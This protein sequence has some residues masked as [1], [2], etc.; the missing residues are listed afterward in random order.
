[1]FGV[2]VVAAAEATTAIIITPKASAAE[3]H[4]AGAADALAVAGAAKAL[5]VARAVKALATAKTLAAGAANK[6]LAAAAA[7]AAPQTAAAFPAAEAGVQVGV[8]VGGGYKLV[9]N[10]TWCLAD[11][12][13]ARRCRCRWGWVVGSLMGG[14]Y[15]LLSFARQSR[16]LAP[17]GCRLRF[18]SCT[19]CGGP[20]RGWRCAGSMLWLATRFACCCRGRHLYKIIVIIIQHHNIVA[21]GCRRS[22]GRLRF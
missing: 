14:R 11:A 3:T 20:R 22:Q 6:T 8:N 2:T 4:T 12:A 17:L 16:G 7:A 19:F 15:R 13:V 1:V 21:D 18:S 9:A 10:G 5:A